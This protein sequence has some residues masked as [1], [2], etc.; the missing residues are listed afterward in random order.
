[1]AEWTGRETE[2]Y[3]SWKGEEKVPYLL[4]G[5]EYDVEIV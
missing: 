3:R 4:A 1:M 5:T 2:L